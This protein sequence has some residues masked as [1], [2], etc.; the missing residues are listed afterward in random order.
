VAKKL[1]KVPTS[2]WR[3]LVEM[4]APWVF[5]AV[6]AV[7]GT[8]LGLREVWTVVLAVVFGLGTTVWIYLYE[9]HRRLAKLRKAR[10]H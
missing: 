2:P 9:R 4:L 1:R 6:G 8:R 10:G 7:I 3:L 5:M